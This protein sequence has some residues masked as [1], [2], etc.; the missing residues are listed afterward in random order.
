MICALCAVEQHR[1]LDQCSDAVRNYNIFVC[2]ACLSGSAKAYDYIHFRW[3][4]ADVGILPIFFSIFHFFFLPARYYWFWYFHVDSIGSC[5]FT[6]A[7]TFA[8]VAPRRITKCAGILRE[9]HGSWVS[10]LQYIQEEF[11]T[12]SQHK[13]AS[14]LIWR[15]TRSSALCWKF[16]ETK[17]RTYDM[18]MKKKRQKQ[19]WWRIIPH[20]IWPKIKIVRCNF[21]RNTT[22]NEICG[23]R[24]IL[25]SSKCPLVMVHGFDIRNVTLLQSQSRPQF[26]CTVHM[27]VEDPHK[28]PLQTNGHIRW[29]YIA[30]GWA[31]ASK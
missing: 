28:F 24:N 14:P 13:C 16:W 19:I 1:F 22:T 9:C 31:R 20:Q 26:M 2:H 7:V 5:S 18:T 23:T 21:H 25:L 10:Q 12:S 8:C 4:V 27:P 29:I 15:K 30:H 6:T 17:S 11:I 3:G